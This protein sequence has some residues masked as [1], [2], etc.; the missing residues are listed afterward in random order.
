MSYGFSIDPA[1]IK[2]LQNQRYRKIME[3]D[4]L[5]LSDIEYQADTGVV[6]DSSKEYF[7]YL[8]SIA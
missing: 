5:I 1:E 4:N 8:M 6:Q 3:N 2:V 7:D